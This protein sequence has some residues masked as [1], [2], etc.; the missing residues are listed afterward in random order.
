MSRTVRAH[1][2]IALIKYWGKKD[3]VNRIPFNSSVSLTLDA[4]YT[5]T[6]VHYDE[7]LTQDVFILDGTV[8]EGIEA[9]RVF[10]F[11]NF[12]RGR[13]DLPF[14][15]RIVSNN[16]VPMAAGL[17]SSASAF[18]ALAKAATLDLDLDDQ[19]VSRLARMGSG[20]ACRSVYGNFAKWERGMDD[21]SSYATPI[22]M[23]PWPEIRMIVCVLN[24]TKKPYSSSYAMKKTSDES[25]YFSAWVKQSEEDLIELEHALQN[26]D[27]K[28]L[29]MISQ[30]NA[31][32]MH[33]SLLAIGMWYF[34]PETIEIMNRIRELQKEIPVYFTMDAGPN[35]KLITTDE[36]I[37]RVLD[38]LTD[39]TTFVSTPGKGLSV[40]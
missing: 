8:M 27:L 31:L 24:D 30:E 21:A 10:D 6:T 17:A 38:A 25:V 2:N 11:M 18:A 1:T 4:F 9:K 28:K 3:D 23:K 19:T 26:H 37:D 20:S 16:H 40:L 35:V 36:Y 34:E 14:F 5:D 29:G 13:Y 32:R 15:A 39:V 12:L 33:A 22:D 7:S